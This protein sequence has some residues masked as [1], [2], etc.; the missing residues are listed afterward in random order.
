MVELVRRGVDAVP[1]LL[2]HLSDARPSKLTVGD[3][4]IMAAWFSDEYDCRYSG[5]ALQP[6]GVNTVGFNSEKTLGKYALRVGD[7]CFVVLGQIVN[8]GYLAVRY[9]PTACLVVNSPV[10]FP[11]L[12]KAARQDWMGLT[13][14]SFKRSLRD[15]VFDEAEF[16]REN[17]GL[18]RLLFY[19]PEDGRAAAM[20]LLKRPLLDHEEIYRFILNDLA[21]AS[22]QQQASMLK[23][24][25]E[26]HGDKYLPF[27]HLYLVQMA[28]NASQGGIREEEGKLAASL[29]S[30]HFA[31]LKSEPTPKRR[32]VSLYDQRAFLETLQDF[33]WDGL[34]D[35]LLSVFRSAARERL[36]TIGGRLERDRLALGCVTRLKHRGYDDEF[37]SFFEDE[38]KQLR[39]EDEE[40]VANR[41]SLPRGNAG[42]HVALSGEIGRIEALVQDLRR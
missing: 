24:F 5:A 11:S 26:T 18:P 6:A 21:Q 16:G 3:G 1:A 27:L 32:Y 14:E 15:D 41:S 33:S 29:L 35:A 12:A 42:Y 34:D 10:E 39:G 25:G 36:W 30:R 22:A 17:G 8:R 4:F 7:L 2:D 20:E 19:Y 23:E 31:E 28:K 13:G 9:Q 38:L 40:A 37:R